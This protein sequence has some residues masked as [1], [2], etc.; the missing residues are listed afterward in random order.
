MAAFHLRKYLYH[1]L[2]VIVF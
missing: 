1:M 2:C